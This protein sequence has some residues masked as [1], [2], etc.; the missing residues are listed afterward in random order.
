MLNL[1]T[2]ENMKNSKIYIKRLLPE[3]SSYGKVLLLLGMLVTAGNCCAFN[4]WHL[5]WYNSNGPKKADTP[6]KS[7]A[8][9][10]TSDHHYY[11]YDVDVTGLGDYSFFLSLTD[12]DDAQTAY[13]NRF[14]TT[15]DKLSGY[16]LRQSNQGE[17]DNIF[18]IWCTVS[19]TLRITLDGYSS[20]L[21]VAS[22]T[23]VTTTRAPSVYIGKKPT[24]VATTATINLQLSDWGCESVDKVKIYYTTDGSTPT[25]VSSYWE[26]TLGS[27]QSSNSNFDVV[28]SSLP[29]GEYNI[30][31]AAHNDQGEGDLSDMA[32]FVISCSSPSFTSQPAEGTTMSVCKN[33]AFS[34]IS[35]TVDGS[36]SSYQWK[37]SDKANGDYTDVTDGTGGT[38]ASFR[39]SSSAIGTLYYK[40]EVT[41]CSTT[42][43]TEYPVACTV[44]GI[45]VTTVPAKDNIHAYEPI[46]LTA[47]TNVN[48]SA[49]AITAGATLGTDAYF[50]DDSYAVVT[51]VSDTKD[52]T[53]K[54]KSGN[55]YTIRATAG[56]CVEDTSFNISTDSETC[57]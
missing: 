8:Q 9:F 50:V 49:Y 57:P 7:N 42:I 35:V 27:E 17:W 56:G 47:S 51:S 18:H 3:F 36:V 52:V 4:E 26:V 39:P 33:V 21:T 45:V 28:K 53:F 6:F 2:I 10:T 43:V 23:P 5:W 38:T 11:T 55:G 48:W 29:I 15:A 32:S 16:S 22:V 40:C 30:K 13:N 1:Q 24:V 25:T 54:G 44:N 19:T 31:V 14:T 34:S 46:K 41:G 12:T 20:T 37:V